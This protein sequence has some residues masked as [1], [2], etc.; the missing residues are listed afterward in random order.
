MPNYNAASL[1]AKIRDAFNKMIVTELEKRGVEGI[2]PSHGD[3][4][5][6]L[7]RDDGLSIKKLA[8]KIHR[9]QPT[10][11]VLVDK[12]EKLGYVKRVKSSE[13]SRVTLIQL[14]GKGHELEPYFR[15]ISAQLNE[16]IYGS[17][18]EQQKE[19]LEN[20]LQQI[21]SRF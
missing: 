18:T 17:L 1:I 9:T 7:Y 2:V 13:D 8:E 20:M 21:Y 15:D 11:T 6:F 14:T 16:I 4:L 12:L 5:M 10:V 19:Q 3:I